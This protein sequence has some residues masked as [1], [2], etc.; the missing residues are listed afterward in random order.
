MMTRRGSMKKAYFLQILHVLQKAPRP[1]T[2]NEIAMF[3]GMS[4]NT[5]DKYIAVLHR[6]RKVKRVK[7][8][9]RYYWSL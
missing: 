7:F 1:L 4:W 2:R 8:H 6:K 5:V 3:T 9:G